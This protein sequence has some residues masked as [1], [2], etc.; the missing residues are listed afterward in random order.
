VKRGLTIIVNIVVIAFI[1]F[2]T[3]KYTSQKREE[4]NDSEL[5][6]FK[7]TAET[8]GQI[9]M[10]YL[11]DEQHL[12]DIWASYINHY[13]SVAGYPMTI[14]EAVE[15]TRRA[16]ISDDVQ[17]HIIYYDDA[18]FKGLSSEPSLNSDEDFTVSYKGYSLFADFSEA[19]LGHEIKQTAAFANPQNGILS[20][21]FLNILELKAETGGTRKAL[22]MRII[23][24]SELSRKL[25]YLKGEYEEM[26][27]AIID[28]A[29]NY[30]IHGSQLKNSNL[31]EYY[32]SYNKTDY[33]SQREFEEQ[34]TGESGLN[35]MTGSKG[36]TCVIAHTPVTPDRDWFLI[37]I[38]PKAGLLPS[39]I[40]WVLLGVTVGALAALL[41]FNMS[42]M[43]VFNRRLVVTAEEAERAN[44]AKSRFL[45]MMSH[46]IR[47]PMNAITGFNEMI[48]RESRDPDILRYSEGIRMADNTLLSLINDI[49]D[50]SKLE[51]GKL[52]II[53]VEYDLVSILNDLVNMI[54]VRTEEKNLALK[55]NIDADIPRKLYGDEL[56]LKQCAI[57]LLSNAVKYTA[58]GTVTFTVGYE[59]CEDN[60]HQILLKFRV[61]DT[62][63]GIKQEDI[64]KLFIAFKRLEEKKNRNIEGSG[65]GL[66]ITQSLLSI[67]G[68]SLEV[69]SEYGKGSTFSF[70]V[71]Q[72]VRGTDKVGEYEEAFRNA[73]ESKG[74]YKRSF[75]APHAKVLV[76]DDTPLNLSVFTGLLK[77]TK[78]NIDTAGSGR[79]ALNLCARNLYDVI[80]LD[81]MMPDMDGIETLHALKVL[82]DNKNVETPVVCLT[83]NAISGM[84]EMFISEGFTDYL[85][86]PIDFVR[87]EQM[88]LKYIPAGKIAVDYIEQ[89]DDSATLPDEVFTIPELDVNSGLSHCGDAESYLNTLRMY[90]EASEKN[91]KEIRDFWNLRDIRNLTIKLHALKSTSRVI[92]AFDVGELAAELEKAGRLGKLGI[93]GDELERLLHAYKEL[94]SKLS[95]IFAPVRSDEGLAPIS[96]EELYEAYD[97]LLKACAEYDYDTVVNVIDELSHRRIPDGEE[98]RMDAIRTASD[99]F[100][101]DVI[102]DIIRAGRKD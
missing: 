4:S 86:K 20:M 64:D 3:A 47:T 21:A 94:S 10:N 61:D 97:K 24:I 31:F 8:A 54:Q 62:G 26:D 76:V 84:R 73:M 57:N 77:A 90:S 35:E 9:I 89:R 82:K 98:T 37:N 16:S 50:F 56:R 101:Y 18:S 70:A 38:I 34:V 71:R 29:G 46:D 83:A 45:S 14:E 11:A 32:K 17:A 28:S 66:S 80:F 88:L 60:E 67:M 52:E 75:T 68:S 81:H 93:L 40:D 69:E 74:R 7:N 1:I 12:C 59:P 95:P 96:K 72:D 102:P 23:P 100:D 55:I 65:L 87:L 36:Q 42:A 25:V 51:A 58:E 41:I 53:P 79:E 22:L 48:S 85:T 5:A 91:E 49:L 30:M 43:M 63:S 13:A 15:F 27:L 19:R 44:D 2:F 33:Q 99:D 39:V 78:V 92:G 6:V